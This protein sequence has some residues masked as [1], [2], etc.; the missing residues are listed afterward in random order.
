MEWYAD[1]L[2]DGL[3]P[4]V[5][6]IFRIPKGKASLSPSLEMFNWSR[7]AGV[8]VPDPLILVHH[9]LGW[10]SLQPVRGLPLDGALI[11]LRHE[12]WR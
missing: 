2:D 4:V 11:F 10:F 3:E 5:P 12:G 9:C 6:Y 8:S 7:S 1:A